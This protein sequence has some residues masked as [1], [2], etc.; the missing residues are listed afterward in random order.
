MKTHKVSGNQV[1]GKIS[2]PPPSLPVRGSFLSN[3]SAYSFLNLGD[4]FLRAATLLN[5]AYENRCEWPTYFLACQALELYLKGYL[6]RRG[7]D[8]D[9]VRK[10]IGHNL[11]LAFDEAKAKGLGLTAEPWLQELVMNVG[12][13]YY[14][15]EFQYQSVGEWSLPLPKALIAFVEQVRL[16][17]GN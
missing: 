3:D 1:A 13:A 11:K 7:R 2:G 5:Q 4:T 8:V 16:A 9:Y 15:R 14:R 12:D 6:L 10:K 17:S